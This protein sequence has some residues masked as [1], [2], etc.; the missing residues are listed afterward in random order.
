MIRQWFQ[1]IVDRG[2]PLPLIIQ[3]YQ[4]GT[5][6]GEVYPFHMEFVI[7]KI[8]AGGPDHPGFHAVCIITGITIIV[9]H[10]FKPGFFLMD[11][12]QFLI[13]QKDL[14]IGLSHIE[15]EDYLF[16]HYPLPLATFLL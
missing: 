4:G 11:Y 14:L 16:L 1:V 6:G 3:V 5:I 7:V 8:L 12:T 9:G 15:N 2:E 10:F 13:E